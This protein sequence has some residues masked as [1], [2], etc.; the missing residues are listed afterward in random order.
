MIALDKVSAP[1]RLPHPAVYIIYL[2]TLRHCLGSGGVGSSFREWFG[3]DGGG[4]S[5]CNSIRA[6]RQG[7]EGIGRDADVGVDHGM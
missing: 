6:A 2:T 1:T 3:Y 5:F 4:E 7:R